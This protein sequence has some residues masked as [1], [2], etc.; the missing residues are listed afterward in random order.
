MKG[1]IF[2]KDI[3]LLIMGNQDSSKSWLVVAVYGYKLFLL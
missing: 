2:Y 3:K 1:K